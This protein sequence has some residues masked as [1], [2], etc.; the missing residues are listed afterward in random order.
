LHHR[1]ASAGLTDLSVEDAAGQGSLA[2]VPASEL[3]TVVLVPAVELVGPRLL[4]C[5][6]VLV[7]IAGADLVERSAG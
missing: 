4:G 5:A 7:G 1:K 2:V 3:L 6:L